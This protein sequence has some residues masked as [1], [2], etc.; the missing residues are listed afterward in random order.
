MRAL[1][2]GTRDVRA[3]EVRVLQDEA[4][5]LK[6]LEQENAR[7]KKIVPATLSSSSASSVCTATGAFRSDNGREFITD[8]SA[9]VF[10]PRLSSS[11]TR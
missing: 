8:T 6:A 7:L 5:R 3:L 4:Q 11:S 9:N 1:Q 2:I 10:Q